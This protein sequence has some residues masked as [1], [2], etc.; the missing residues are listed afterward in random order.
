MQVR[1]FVTELVKQG[2]APSTVTKSLRILS[3]ILKA[4]V[5][6]RL[7]PSNPC[8]GVEGPGEARWKKRSSSARRR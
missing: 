2:L 3:Q 7:I 8:E 1:A 5:R 6:N 4:G